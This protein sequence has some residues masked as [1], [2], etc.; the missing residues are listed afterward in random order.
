MIKEKELIRLSLFNSLIKGLDM[1]LVFFLAIHFTNIDLTGAQ[2]GTIFALGSLT[3]ILTILPSGFS[4]DRFN[5]KHLITFSLTLFAIFYLGLAFT[6]NFYAIIALFLT[7]SIGKNLYTAASQ[8]LF[9]KSSQNEN[10]KKKISLFQSLHYISIG[11]AVIIAGYLLDINYTFENLFLIIGGLFLAAAI[12]GQ[13]ILPTNETAEFNIIHYKQD[14][15]KPAILFFMVIV[16]LFSLHIGAEITSY[17]LFLKENLKLQPL[18]QGLYMGIAILFMAV[19]VIL[20]GKKLEHLKAKNVLL[21]GLFTSGLGLILMNFQ[22]PHIS[23]LFRIIHEIGDSA[24]FFFLYYGVS[25][26]FDLNRIGGNNGIFLLII[27]I[28]A[29]IGAFFCAPIGE[30]YGYNIALIFGGAT[31]LIACA[32]TIPFTHL[33]HHE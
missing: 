32:L 16:F 5:S 28:G 20:L 6:Q 23:L 1:M 27:S 14:L 2:I 26:M 9:Y 8:S 33:I 22:N 19:S 18:N 25:K 15:F 31:T 12:I 29:T 11:F 17:G 30:T 24:V 3:A 13:F 4:S 21:V 7:G 10:L